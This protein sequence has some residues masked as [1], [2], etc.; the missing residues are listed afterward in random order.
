MPFGPGHVS[1]MPHLLPQAQARG[2]WFWA[3]EGASAASPLH[4]TLEPQHPSYLPGQTLSLTAAMLTR[5]FVPF[6]LPVSGSS[7]SVL[8]LS[9][10]L[11]ARVTL[12]C[13]GRDH[14]FVFIRGK[15]WPPH[16]SLPSPAVFPAWGKGG[17]WFS[18]CRAAGAGPQGARSS[19]AVTAG[20]AG[21]A[22]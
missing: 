6:T 16:G 22:C 12:L 2:P 14:W 17:L 13:L 5:W 21:M 4:P 15:E 10:H 7:A 19:F 20:L 18:A 3:A 8:Y 11:P 9:S 1:C